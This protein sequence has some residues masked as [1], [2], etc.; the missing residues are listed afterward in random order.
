MLN[1]IF[2]ISGVVILLIVLL[3]IAVIHIRSIR[4]DL[5]NR[6]YN[7]AEK[8]QY[9]Q[10]LMPNLIE[11]VKLFIPA[12]NLAA[13]KNLIQK[14]IDSRLAAA[15]N[16][17]PGTDKIIEENEISKQI[18]ELLKLGAKYESLGKSTNYLELKKEIKDLR[19]Q[20]EEL[21][22]NYNNKVRNY[23]SMLSRP[24]NILP[25]LLMKYKRKY[26]FDFE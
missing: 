12:E 16:I 4:D 10:D 25:G 11:T 26:I 17:K 14:S 13:H 7:L 1:T 6:W 22:S 8:L 21:T 20:I 15:K 18:E 5:E 3:S 23:N 24:Y 19:I 2:L 9:R